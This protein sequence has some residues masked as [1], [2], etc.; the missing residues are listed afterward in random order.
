M[1]YEMYQTCKLLVNEAKERDIYVRN[2]PI[3][4]KVVR[5]LSVVCWVRSEDWGRDRCTLLSH[6]VGHGQS[7]V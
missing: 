3:S 6:V 7:G 2:S 4:K 1:K 5:M